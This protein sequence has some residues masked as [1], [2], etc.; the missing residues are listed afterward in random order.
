MGTQSSMYG[1]SKQL[2]ER[3]LTSIKNELLEK[4]VATVLLRSVFLGPYELTTFGG[5]F[6]SSR[7]HFFTSDIVTWAL[8]FIYPDKKNIEISAE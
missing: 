1:P 2:G 7:G 8:I 3:P 5:P 4:D 6:M